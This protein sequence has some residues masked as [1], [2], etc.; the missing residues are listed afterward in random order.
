[1]RLFGRKIPKAVGESGEMPFFDHLE[2]LR[3]RIIW[4][5]IA[6]VVGTI[7]GFVVSVQWDLL[8]I[9]KRPLDPYIQDKPLV[10]LTMTGPF[11]MTFKLALTIGVVLAIPVIV[12]QIW[13][14]LAPALTKRE[15]RTIMPALGMGVVLFTIGVLLGY[16]WVLPPTV[17]F[18][19]TFQTPSMNFMLTADKYFS[20]VISLLVAMG[21]IFELPVVVMILA[22]LRLV[23]AK[24]LAAKRRHALAG[25]TVIAALITPG[26]A[27]TAMVFMMVPLVLLY[28]LGIVLT[29]LIERSRRREA[30]ADSLAEGTP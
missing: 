3:W 2:E 4:S 16:Y 18:F 13:S 12:Y 7:I 27:I 29:K 22:T 10:S 20:F 30:L 6:L 26:D 9:L 5:V 1:M 11:M 23:T 15:R 19:D 25:M 24:F 28:E 14:F 17:K 21:A 8:S